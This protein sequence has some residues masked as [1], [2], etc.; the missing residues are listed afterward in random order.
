[1]Q[2]EDPE[3]RRLLGFWDPEP[4][5]PACLPFFHSGCPEWR[6]LATLDP[7]GVLDPLWWEPPEIRFNGYEDPVT[8]YFSFLVLLGLVQLSILVS[9]GLCRARFLFKTLL[10]LEPFLADLCLFLGGSMDPPASLL[11]AGVEWTEGWFSLSA[12]LDPWD[13][14]PESLPGLESQ[15]LANWI[16]PWERC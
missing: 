12:T 16:L 7:D 14:D 3:A 6:D 15:G 1:L 9:S 8:D 5:L 10:A 13:P 4:A 2:V 11:G